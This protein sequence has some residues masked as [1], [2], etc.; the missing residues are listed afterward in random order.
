MTL[1]AEPRGTKIC[2]DRRVLVKAIKKKKELVNNDNNQ[3]TIFTI[4]TQDK[5]T[6]EPHWS[7]Y[8]FFY[9][10]YFVM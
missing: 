5:Y 6:L 4:F 3:W 8:G 7:I 2:H 9:Y 10:Y 1:V